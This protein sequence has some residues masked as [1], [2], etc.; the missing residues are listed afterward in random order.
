MRLVLFIYNLILIIAL[1]F[2]FVITYIFAYK[3]NDTKFFGERFGLIKLNHSPRQKSVWFHAASVGEVR[4]VK[5]IV[6]NIRTKCPE[7]SIMVS[8]MTTAGR[9]TAIDYL[10]ADEAFLLP[11]E[12]ALAIR[13]LIKLMGVK[14]FFVVDTEI[15]PNMINAAAAE[16]TLIMINGRV[17][18][19]TYKS[20]MRFKFIFRYVLR[21]FTKIFVKS[22]EDKIR[23][24]HLLDRETNVETL[25]NIKFQNRKKIEDIARI[26]EFQ[27]KKIFLATSTHQKEEE[28]ILTNIKEEEHLFD[29]II[30]TPRHIARS[31]EIKKIAEK[32]GYNASL[33]SEKNPNT[34]VVIIDAF[35]ILENLYVM[36][37]KIFIGGSIAEI[38]GHN[39]Y[40]AL[41]FY[42][43][44]GCGPNIQNFAEI[45]H[46]AQ[47][48]KLAT[49]FISK[50]EFL[51]WVRT[52]ENT[53]RQ[54]FD[55]F[56]KVIDEK[57]KKIL[58]A[59]TNEAEK[60]LKD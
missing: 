7:T 54:K 26:K 4:S 25:G 27:N 37:N 3:K 21:K 42:K 28:Y 30:I 56:F 45:F 44:V 13:Y 53:H 51:N 59:I 19:R 31:V 43:R 49:S 15:W 35:G 18:R 29:K 46:D 39:I 33:Y 23:F 24:E 58:D 48:F 57:N 55:D 6:D 38:G 34:E 17:S 52:E 32:L 60:C 10:K 20:Y 9:A 36:S 1:P 12:N 22:G 8:T 47:E 2:I 40:E 11:I 16:T 41:Q 5:D 14:I 50:D